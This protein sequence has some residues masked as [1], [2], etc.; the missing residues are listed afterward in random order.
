MR[1]RVRDRIREGVRGKGVL[2]ADLPLLGRREQQ[3]I[4]RVEHR[5]ARAAAA[6]GVRRREG[7]EGAQVVGAHPR[8][9]AAW[10]GGGLAV[11]T[12]QRTL[13]LPLP[14]PLPLTLPLTL[15]LTLTLNLVTLTLTL[16]LTG[17]AALC[18]G[19][20]LGAHTGRGQ[21]PRFVQASPALLDPSS[22]PDHPHHPPCR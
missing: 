5:A 6:G 21:N 10:V 19:A 11:A 13:T 18:D 17:D 15:T 1:V 3:N 14:L 20:R 8:H 7:E 2:G 22:G 12:W 16:T 9:V 4:R